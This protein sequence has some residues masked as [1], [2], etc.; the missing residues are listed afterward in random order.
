VKLFRKHSRV[1][2]PLG[3]KEFVEKL[4]NLTGRILKPQRPGRKK[5]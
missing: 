4:E 2:R 1:G 3:K 5:K